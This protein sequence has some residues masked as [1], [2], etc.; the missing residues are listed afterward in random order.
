[1]GP[2]NLLA[3]RPDSSG[4]C[5]HV[6]PGDARMKSFPPSSKPRTQL[7]SR[8]TD[9]EAFYAWLSLSLPINRATDVPM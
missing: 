1:M 3:G 6:A 4:L 7:A 8:L 5:V 9:S 2:G